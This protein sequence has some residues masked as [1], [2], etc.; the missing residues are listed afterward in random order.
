MFPSLGDGQGI[1]EFSL[2]L[3]ELELCQRRPSSEEIEDG[4]DECLLLGGEFYA[5]GGGD[6]CAFDLERSDILVFGR[7][8]SGSLCESSCGGL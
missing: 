2:I 3:P 7:H 5:R 6:I 1:D 4:A 8:G